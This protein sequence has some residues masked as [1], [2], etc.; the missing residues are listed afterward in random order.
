MD[1]RLDS[2][3]RAKLEDLVTHF[4]RSRAAVLREVM[5][6][7]LG[8]GPLGKPERDDTHGPF[9]S[10]FFEAKAA[11]HQQVGKAA[12]RAGMDVAPWLRHL[13]RQITVED[14]LASW[15]AGDAPR[16]PTKGG[17]SHDS[18]DYDQRLMVRLDAETRQ[19]LER[20]S[21]RFH[22]SM[23]EVIRQ[24]AGQAR[25]EDFPLS[26]QMAVQ[27]RQPAPERDERPGGHHI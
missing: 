20:F 21:S 7:D 13:L 9:H 8:R 3:T 19:R 15:R 17:R 4:R 27:E 26:C 5:Q 24:L 6:G 16:R 14:F 1:A 11:L 2:M 10:L 23:A 18:R 12:R 25:L 22:Q